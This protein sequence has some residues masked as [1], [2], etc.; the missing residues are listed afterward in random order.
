MLAACED[1][2]A[3]AASANVINSSQSQASQM[4]KCGRNTAAV[5]G[6]SRHDSVAI[7]Q[8]IGFRVKPQMSLPFRRKSTLP[9]GINYDT[10]DVLWAPGPLNMRWNDY[11]CNQQM[12]CS[13]S[14]T[15]RLG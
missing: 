11:I 9:V 8:Q 6:A 5:K 13:C 10:K 4:V 1:A 7:A 14:K 2:A 15:V 3:A 12:F